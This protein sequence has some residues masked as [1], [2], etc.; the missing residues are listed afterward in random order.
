[1]NGD[2]MSAMGGGTD[3]GAGEGEVYTAKTE[4]EVAF[5]L[6]AAHA[7]VDKKFYGFLREDPVAA[8]ASLHM[9]LDE[10]DYEYLRGL[11]TETAPGVE[12]ERLDALADEIR[13][14]LHADTVVRSL[15]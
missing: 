9:V 4:R 15:W 1:M 14:S 8:V 5:K 13:E 10:S 12:W 7:L 11:G 3:G 6:L 2:N